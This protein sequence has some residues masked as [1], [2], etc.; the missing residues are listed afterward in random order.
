M[1][2]IQMR[3]KFSGTCRRCGKVIHAGEDHKAIH[4]ACPTPDHCTYQRPGYPECG[5]EYDH[6]GACLPWKSKTH[7]V[8]S[9]IKREEVNQVMNAFFAEAEALPFKP[10]DPKKIPEKRSP[11]RPSYAET[12]VRAIFNSAERSVEVDIR[13]HERL[14]SS[15]VT[16]LKKAVRKQG[17]PLRVVFVPDYTKPDEHGHYATGRVFVQRIDMDLVR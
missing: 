10:I 15:A 2:V 8:I 4:A 7:D 1:A 3:S 5:L 17:L 16:A 6:P 11:A 12:T 9:T 13:S 14:P